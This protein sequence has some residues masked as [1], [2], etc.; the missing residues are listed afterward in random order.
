[1]ESQEHIDRLS[2]LGCQYGQG[3]FIGQAMTAKQ[4]IDALSGVPYSGSKK[5]VM[6]LLW[7]RMVGDRT[8][9][10]K[11]EP[12]IAPPPVAEKRE[13]KRRRPAPPPPPPEPEAIDEEVERAAVVEPEPV[14]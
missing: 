9:K 13:S 3:F 8:E 1:I 12:A 7:E 10:R 14:E 11:N 6:T 2:A 5:N 4:V